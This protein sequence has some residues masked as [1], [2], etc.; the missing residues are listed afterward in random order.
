MPQISRKPLSKELMNRINELLWEAFAKLR[1][2]EDAATFIQ[3]IFTTTEKVMIAKRLAIALLLAR[4]WDQ[5]AISSYLKVSTGT[6]QTI[7]RNLN[8]Q[9]QGYRKVINQIEESGE[10]EQMKLDLAQ[11]FEEILAGR[12]GVNWKRSK[13]AVAQKYRQKRAKYKLL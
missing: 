2:K 13:P 8:S 9:S 3:D 10:W 4:G 5:E 11:A 7:K 12:V 1:G 6:V